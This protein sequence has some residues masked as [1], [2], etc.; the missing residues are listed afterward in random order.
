MPLSKDLREFVELLNSNGVEY[1]IVGAFAVA[2]YGYPRYTADLDI[3]I[4]PAI[5][6]AERVLATLAQ[7]GLGSLGIYSEDLTTPGKVIQLS[8]KPNRIDF[9]LPIQALVLKK[10]GQ[11]EWKVCLTVLRSAILGAPSLYLTRFQLVAPKI[12]AC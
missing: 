7:F 11:L 2:W 9:S 8:I 3:L 10:S 6:N 1:V 5:S 12:K 4:R